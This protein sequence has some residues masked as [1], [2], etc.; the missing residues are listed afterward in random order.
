MKVTPEQQAAY[1]V[2]SYLSNLMSSV[3][4]SIWY[5]WH[6]THIDSSDPTNPEAHYGLI[7]QDNHDKL[8]LKLVADILPKIR[9]AIIEKQ[10][11]S[12][13]SDAFALLMRRANGQ[14]FLIFWSGAATSDQSSSLHI[15]TEAR[16]ETYSLT[17]L[18]QLLELSDT[19]PQ[20]SFEP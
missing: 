11:I 13:K 20:V 14:H 6:D 4:L 18:P 17:A 8:S 5:E 9:D 3:P 16:S 19:K 10:F 7:A 2:R 15:T 12:Q 1:V